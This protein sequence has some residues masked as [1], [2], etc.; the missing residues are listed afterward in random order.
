MSLTTLS[1]GTVSFPSYVS[2]DEANAYLLAEPDISAQWAAKTT[3]QKA[4]LLIAATRRIDRVVFAGSKTDPAQ[5]TQWPRSGVTLNTGVTILSTA[6]PT[7]VEQAT[8]L[9]AGSMAVSTA[10]A[11]A[12]D[13]GSNKKRVKAGAVEVEFFRSDKGTPLGNRAAYEALRV[14][15]LL[16]TPASV[17]AGA[18]ASG[19]TEGTFLYDAPITRLRGL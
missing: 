19:T 5:S 9:L 14:E 8:I 18:I 1:I 7:Q 10:V 17:G 11:S 13:S 3:D 15:G 2:L 4:A 12:V 16:E 6:I